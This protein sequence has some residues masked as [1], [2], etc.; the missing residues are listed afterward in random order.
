[1]NLFLP[2]SEICV[3]TLSGQS[4]TS[5]CLNGQDDALLVSSHA[6]AIQPEG[7]GHSMQRA[8][9]ELW[10]KVLLPPHSHITYPGHITWQLCGQ[11][12]IF[13][14]KHLAGQSYTFIHWCCSCKFLGLSCLKLKLTC[15]KAAWQLVFGGP[16]FYPWNFQM[17]HVHCYTQ[18]TSSGP[19]AGSVC[20]PSVGLIKRVTGNH[21]GT[22][23]FRSSQNSVIEVFSK[24][25]STST[26]HRHGPLG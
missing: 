8:A 12:A 4:T 2:R 21:S 25:R 1:M 20:A 24:P 6:A 15:A 18:E 9:W 16:G 23:A 7:S 14:L 10:V 13:S 3:W 22:Q 11:A 19:F 5:K 26:G 17:Q